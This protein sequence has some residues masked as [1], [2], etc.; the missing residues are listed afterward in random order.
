MKI[1]NLSNTI[2]AIY[3]MDFT[4]NIIPHIWYQK[5]TFNN[6]KADLQAITIL[7][8]ILYWY[9]PEEI[10]DNHTG[11][12]IGLK[13][14]FKADMLQ[15]STNKIA[16]QFGMT[17]RQVSDALK[18]LS[19][20]GLIIKE[21]RQIKTQIGIL[22]NVLFLAPVVEKIIELQAATSNTDSSDENKNDEF[23]INEGNYLFPIPGPHQLNLI[24]TKLE[25]TPL[26]VQTLNTQHP[27]AH[28]STSKRITYTEI[29]T[30]N[31]SENTTI[32]TAAENLKLSFA[33]TVTR[34]SK[35]AAA[36]I[37]YAKNKS[38][39]TS[40]MF[41][42]DPEQNK[43]GDVVIGSELTHS[44]RLKIKYYLDENY[45]RSL[46]YLGEKNF[47]LQA[48]SVEIL[49]PK[50]FTKTHGNFNHKFNA[51]KKSIQSNQWHPDQCIESLQNQ[52]V[53]H[54]KK[55]KEL[56]NKIREIELDRAGA[57]H[58]LEIWKGNT[59][60]I[61][62]RKNSIA[63]CDEALKSTLAELATIQKIKPQTFEMN[64]K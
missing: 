53:G 38:F 18:R 43:L 26:Y 59:A 37:N 21:Q 3:Q 52:Q 15:R 45:E 40:V 63:T 29:S 14:K 1:Y 47:L 32:T 36:D 64:C 55:L 10:R 41:T 49:S 44:Q 9:R 17:R 2:Q 62:C 24:D 25:C 30:K 12:L 50:S 54:E 48:L 23:G 19:D 16:H 39:S 4:G 51:I 57:L 13:K 56:K 35:F 6:G 60:I 20:K 27:N 28:H 22:P 46:K 11:T 61:E 58:D 5:I 33:D 34:E 8:D 31:S 7:S 42:S